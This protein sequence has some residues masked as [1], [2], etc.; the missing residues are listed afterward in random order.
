MLRKTLGRYL[1]SG[2]I[3]AEG[4]R[5]RLVRRIVNPLFSQANIRG[6]MPHFKFK[7]DELRSI[8]LERIQ[9]SISQHGS[10]E[11]GGAVLMDV[12]DGLNRLS[13][14]IIGLTA[15]D[16]PFD[17]LHGMEGKLYPVKWL[18]HDGAAAAGTRGA[19]HVEKQSEFDLDPQQA[20]VKDAASHRQAQIQQS[21]QKGH[22][23]G[24]RIYEAYDRMFD[25]CMGRT[26]L[27]GMLSVMF[28]V[29]D[30]LFVSRKMP[31]YTTHSPFPRSL[32][33]KYATTY[34][35]DRKLATGQGRNGIH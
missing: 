10:E 23:E 9:T 11:D 28:P 25:V 27:R 26:D 31:D 19:A 6:M 21:V 1:R 29:L 5:H 4:P 35:A 22:G 18:E 8:W 13:F 14:D 15:F 12:L 17:A 24:S 7:C 32:T 16:H 33:N 20:K 34:S 30:K 2:L 3:N